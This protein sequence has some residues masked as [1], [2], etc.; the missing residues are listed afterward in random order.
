MLPIPP[1]PS[2][3]SSIC[4][5]WCSR[6]LYFFSFAENL[7]IL[8]MF[9]YILCNTFLHAL[10]RWCAFSC[11]NFY[12]YTRVWQLDLTSIPYLYNLGW[13]NF[14]VDHLIP[15]CNFGPVQPKMPDFFFCKHRDQILSWS[16]WIWNSNSYSMWNLLI[17][18][19]WLFR[20]PNGSRMCSQC[21][22]AKGFG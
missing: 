14:L 4:Y 13:V 3:F 9:Y 12:C 10:H 6:A 7:K 15:L 21:F 5:C 22:V 16:W 1:P 17:L 19:L 20:F 8:P 11:F 2:S 18:F